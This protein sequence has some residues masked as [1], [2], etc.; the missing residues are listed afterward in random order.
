MTNIEQI[1]QPYDWENAPV[2]CELN[3]SKWILGPEADE[4]ELDW[5]AAIEWCTSVG[6]ELPPR[7]VL[8]MCYMNEDIKKE[9][10]ATYYWSSAE[11]TVTIA[12]TQNFS[13][14][15]QYNHYK[16]IAYYVRAVRRLD[17]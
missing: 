2:I 8:L 3:G 17:I 13:N 14:G 10:A 1:Q 7:E 5:D 4:E 12:G 9:F 6:G 15:T 16:S 11:F